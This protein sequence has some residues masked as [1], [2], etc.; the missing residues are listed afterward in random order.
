MMHWKYK[1][2]F[3]TYSCLDPTHDDLQILSQ[4]I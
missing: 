2:G 3:N 1:L 4:Q